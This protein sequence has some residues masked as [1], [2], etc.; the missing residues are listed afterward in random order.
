MER[1]EKAIWNKNL[2]PQDK[3]ILY[4]IDV[5]HLAQ[6]YIILYYNTLVILDIVV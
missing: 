6:S 4:F 3:I 2:S 1:R 5:S